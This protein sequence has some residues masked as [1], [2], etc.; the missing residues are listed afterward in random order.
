MTQPDRDLQPL[1]TCRVLDLTE[2]GFNWCG[3]V[4]ADFGADVIKIEPPAG[5]PTRAVGPFLDG[6]PGPDR[7]LYWAAYC[8]N[9]R[10]V[11][12]ERGLPGWTGSTQGL[13]RRR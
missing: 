8:V 10:G 9:K 11:T 1:T 2:G 7:S 13:G 4:L 3:K 12:I 5:S 6:E